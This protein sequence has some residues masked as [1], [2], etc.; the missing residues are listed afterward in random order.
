VSDRGPRASTRFGI[1]A[2]G[3]LALAS[4]ALAPRVQASAQPAALRDALCWPSLL[5][6]P[7]APA[8]GAAPPGAGFLALLLYFAEY[9]VVWQLARAAWRRLRPPS[10]PPSP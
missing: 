6:A 5:V 1:L 9:L 8:S 7:L 3:L 2:C 10:R 4:V